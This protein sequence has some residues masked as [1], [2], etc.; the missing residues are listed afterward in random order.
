VGEISCGW[1]EEEKKAAILVSVEEAKE[2]GIAK[3]RACMMWGISRRR[4][5]R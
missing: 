2:Q 3:S 4:V 1:L 5:N